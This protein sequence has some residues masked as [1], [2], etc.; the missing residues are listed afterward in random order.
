MTVRANTRGLPRVNSTRGFFSQFV[1]T[2]PR[3]GTVTPSG[4]TR[5]MMMM[6]M[7]VMMMIMM[8]MIRMVSVV[9]MRMIIDG[10]DDGDGW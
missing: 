3:P 2:V 5:M 10:D 6:V 8:A 7:M 9:M 1:A 4:Q